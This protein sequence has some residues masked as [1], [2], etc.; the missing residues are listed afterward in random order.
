MLHMKLCLM[1]EFVG[2]LCTLLRSLRGIEV[3][4]GTSSNTTPPLHGSLSHGNF[5][6]F[7]EVCLG[8]QFISEPETL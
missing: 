5:L 1:E 3:R 4:E 7:P 2:Q 8:L 6:C